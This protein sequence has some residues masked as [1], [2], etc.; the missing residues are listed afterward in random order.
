MDKSDLIL[1]TG[2]AGFIGSYMLGALN[3]NGFEN[4]IIADH[5]GEEKKL[6]NYEGKKFAQQIERDELF[7][8]LSANNPPIKYVLHLGARTDTT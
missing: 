7:E 3:R 5:F 1:L 8:W 4:I 6:K 2:A